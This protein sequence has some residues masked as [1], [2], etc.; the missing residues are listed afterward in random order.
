MKCISLVKFS[1]CFIFVTQAHRRKLTTRKFHSCCTR[2]RSWDRIPYHHW[3]GA[4]VSARARNVADT[5]AVERE[6]PLAT[7]LE[8]F[9][10]S[11]SVLGYNCLR[12][13]RFCDRA[14]GLVE[15][16]SVI[17]QERKHHRQVSGRAAEPYLYSIQHSNEKSLM[18]YAA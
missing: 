5:H 7:Y 6:L 3:R 17:F 1:P 16:S 4:G 15:K 8:R 14:L 13:S 12:S 10:L 11:V 9:H 2:A 18:L